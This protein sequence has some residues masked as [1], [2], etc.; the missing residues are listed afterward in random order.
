MEDFSSFSFIFVGDTHGFVNDFLKQKEII[1]AVNPDYVLSEQL[2]DFVLDSEEKYVLILKHKKIS[3]MVKFE[4]V[5]DL[6]DLCH[7]KGVKIIGMDINNFGF[8]SQLQSVVRGEKVA[9]KE[10]NERINMIMKK[11]QTHHLDV[12]KKYK[13]LTKKPVIILIGSWHLQENSFLMRSL[14]N[15]LVIYPSDVQG[16]ML[17]EPPKNKTRISYELRIKR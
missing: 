6:L 13:V 5:K 11:R 4:E 9:S 3:G 15:Y 10:D 12:I 17:L 2:Q 16:R 14:N 1:N 8:D 7:Q